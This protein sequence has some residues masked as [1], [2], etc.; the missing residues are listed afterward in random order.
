MG[1]DH[2]T[3]IS[4]VAKI[5]ISFA[6]WR[7]FLHAY[8]LIIWLNLKSK[9]N[10]KQ[11]DKKWWSNNWR[12]HLSETGRMNEAEKRRFQTLFDGSPLPV[13]LWGCSVVVTFEL[14][15]YFYC[16]TRREVASFPMNGLLRTYNTGLLGE[17]YLDFAERFLKCTSSSAAL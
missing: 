15:A 17:S 4:T 11:V 14:S 5:L 6:F 9:N 3:K 12:P 7:T 1:L 13:W 16:R 8:S 10:N 2:S